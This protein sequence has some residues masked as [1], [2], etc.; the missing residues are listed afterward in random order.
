MRV[1]DFIV[2]IVAVIFCIVA[3]LAYR[4]KKQSDADILHSIEFE[5]KVLN[6]FTQLFTKQADIGQ[7]FIQISALVL[8]ATAIFYPILRLTGALTMP[9]EGGSHRRFD[10]DLAV[11]FLL[12][13]VA[14]K[15]TTILRRP[16]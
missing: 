14:F 7:T 9:F 8:W 3:A 1:E 15:L 16:K 2:L 5:K 11:I 4:K 13:L 10:P 12:V 6:S